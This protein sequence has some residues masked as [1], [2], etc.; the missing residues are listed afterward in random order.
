MATD[1]TMDLIRSLDDPTRFVRK[2]RVAVFKPHRR[3][4]PDGTE[5]VVTAGDL[6]EIAANVNRTYEQDGELVKLTIGH[7]KQA[8][9]ADETTQ[10]RVVGYARNLKAEMVDRPGGK[11]LR[12]TH[13]EYVRREDEAEAGRHPGRSPEYDPAG[14]TITAVA[15]LTRDPALTLGTVGYSGGRRLYWSESMAEENGTPGDEFGP[16]DEVQYAAFCKYMK[17]YMAGM[18]GDNGGLPAP[19]E[20]L[21]PV[22]YQKELVAVKTEVEKIRQERDADR[23]T[24]ITERSGRLLD[25]IKDV[26]KFDY[27]RELTHLASLPDDAARGAHVQYVLANYESLPYARDM[28]PVLTGEVPVPGARPDPNDPTAAPARHNEIVT[29]M[30]ANPGLTYE[31][32]EARVLAQK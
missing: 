13:T 32:A 5:V 26:K 16:D 31:A 21:P 1:P 23:K 28:L 11:V 24:L 3:K 29:Y 19:A 10:P 22:P 15:L 8:A 27:Q 7:R 4:F 9:D 14:K 20:S 18:G 2:D 25:Q 30:R 17:K 12:L 6:G